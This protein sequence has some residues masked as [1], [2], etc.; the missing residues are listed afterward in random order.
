MSIL[1]FTHYRIKAHQN[2][3]E[4]LYGGSTE[5]EDDDKEC[6]LLYLCS[7]FCVYGTYMQLALLHLLSRITNTP[8]WTCQTCLAKIDFYYMVTLLTPI[9]RCW[10]ATSRLMMGKRL[11][12]FMC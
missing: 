6:V 4:D 2:I 8:C 7:E 12:E 11:L 1:F 9:V 10:Y 5:E 3:E